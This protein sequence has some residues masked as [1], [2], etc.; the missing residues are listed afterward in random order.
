[1]SLDF[2]SLNI[3]FCNYVHSCCS[4][5]SFKNGQTWPQDPLNPYSYRRAPRVSQV[6]YPMS[7]RGFI[8]YLV[9]PTLH[10]PQRI[11]YSWKFTPFQNRYM[12]ILSIFSKPSLN[13]NSCLV[14]LPSSSYVN[15][16]HFWAQTT[17]PPPPLDMFHVASGLSPLHNAVRSFFWS[18]NLA[19]SYAYVNLCLKKLY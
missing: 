6:G 10:I 1:M 7:W 13:C 11:N 4:V 16:L 18:I 9:P 15:M 19:L 5:L 2:F 14:Q 3:L 12:N 8:S 17:P